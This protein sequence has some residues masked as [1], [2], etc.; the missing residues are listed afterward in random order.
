[1]GL[2][3][4]RTRR[5]NVESSSVIN[6]LAA[7]ERLPDTRRHNLPA[8]LTSFVGRPKELEELL[9][10]L[11]SSRLLSLMGAG[12]VGKTRLAVRLAS[13]YVNEFRMA[14]GWSTWR[15]S[16]RPLWWRRR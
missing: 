3:G 4:D 11:G 10:L 8:D 14:C 12:G 1:V 9:R 7:S 15:P 6:S 13:D 16:Q 2:S 5:A